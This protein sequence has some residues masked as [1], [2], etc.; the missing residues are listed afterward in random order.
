MKPKRYEVHSGSE[1]GHCC[2]DFTVIDT[3]ES[4]PSGRTGEY[5]AVCETFEREEADLIAKAL[6][7]QA[8]RESNDD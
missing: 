6:N 1:S 3:R 7:E 4:H 2:F 5:A 8:E